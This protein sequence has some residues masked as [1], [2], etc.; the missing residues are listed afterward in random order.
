M[1]QCDSGRCC[2]GSACTDSKKCCCQTA[3]G[4]F[5]PGEVCRTAA[6][7][8]G[9]GC[10]YVSVCEC[11][12]LGGALSQECDP[13]ANVTCNPLACQECQDG[14]CVNLCGPCQDCYVSGL[15]ASCDP[16]EPP[17]LCMECVP[18]NND[19]GSSD[20]FFRKTGNPCGSV[21]CELGEC[22][23]GGACVSVCTGCNQC[24]DGQCVPIAGEECGDTCCQTPDTC[25]GTT[26]CPP[27]RAC[28]I[29]NCCAEGEV[30]CGGDCAECNTDSDCGSGFHCAACQCVQFD[31]CFFD[32]RD[33]G[34]PSSI[35][36]YE[37]A[38]PDSYDT[39]GPGGPCRV[40]V[41]PLPCEDI[42]CTYTWDGSQWVLWSGTHGAYYSGFSVD[43]NGY[44]VLPGSTPCTCENCPSID[45]TIPAGGPGNEYAQGQSCSREEN[46][47]P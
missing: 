42:K 2:K 17:E 25:C 22:C 12:N 13:C 45:T 30:C 27:G 47:L 38:C 34:E 16:V 32:N 29:G 44:V 40:E 24:Q 39:I 7:N 41:T 23:V 28:C 14:K 26:C 6:C 8:L 20:Y 3:G 46:P 19:D 9:G 31:L 35:A 1:A 36:T 15:T 18:K 37:S 21:C 10:D 5:T 4:T 11:E 33:C 43:G